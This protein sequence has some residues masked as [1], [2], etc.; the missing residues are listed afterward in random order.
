M[1]PQVLLIPGIGDSGP[2][3]WQT[4]W[5]NSDAGFVRVQQ[6]N[7][8][9][10]VYADWAAALETSVAKIPGEVVLVA[11]SLGCL[12]T[13]NWV[14]K[15]RLTI[16]AALLVAVPDPSGPAFPTEATGFAPPARQPLPCPS[17][18]VASSNDPYST[19]TYSASCAEAW[20][21]R[22]VNLGDAG[23]INTQSG[24]GAWP[25]GRLLLN[26]LLDNRER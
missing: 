7:W 13:V 6:H 11:H 3:H 19:L 21:S 9:E 16:K 8:H 26:T 2:D 15:T 14:V 17:I 1:Q 25:Q 18:L 12:L 23:H 24:L 10:P 5:E 4:L 20:G 22:L